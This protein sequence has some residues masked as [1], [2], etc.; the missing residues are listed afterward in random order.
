MS[1]LKT[2]HTYSGDRKQTCV[3][4]TGAVGKDGTEVET[5]LT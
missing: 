4:E 1:A 3:S 2:A 5:R